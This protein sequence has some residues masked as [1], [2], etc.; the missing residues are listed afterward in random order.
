[1]RAL[2]STAPAAIAPGARM[3][4]LNRRSVGAAIATAGMLLGVSGMAITPAGAA[5]KDSGTVHIAGGDNT[6]GNDPHVEC[7]FTVELIGFP[8]GA[9]ADLRFTAQAPTGDQG[10]LLLLED[11]LVGADPDPTVDI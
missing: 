1:C 8:E 2:P 9:V 3:K 10:L 7:E 4:L 5:P 11:V 6:P